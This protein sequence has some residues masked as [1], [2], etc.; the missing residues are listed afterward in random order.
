M[1]SCLT[2]G[3]TGSLAVPFTGKDQMP[4]TTVR[5]CGFCDAGKKCHASY[6]TLKDPLPFPR[7]E[8]EPYQMT[9]MKIF[10]EMSGAFVR[11]EKDMMKQPGLFD[12]AKAPPPQP[13]PPP[14]KEKILDISSSDYPND[15]KAPAFDVYS[16][17]CDHKIS[18]EEGAHW[19]AR[20]VCSRGLPY[21]AELATLADLQDEDSMEF[22]HH[23]VWKKIKA[24]N[25]LWKGANPD[26]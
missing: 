5:A 9:L 23:Q 4:Y 1:T 25:G 24:Y 19:L 18:L 20:E 8:G 2:C 21:P 13:L 16:M 7:V 3:G 10:S 12:H 15:L 22:F 6:P 26:V 14:A 11:R 17:A